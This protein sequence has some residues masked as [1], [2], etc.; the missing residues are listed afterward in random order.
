VTMTYRIAPAPKFASL[1]EWDCSRCGRREVKPVFLNDGTGAKAFGSGCAARLL[2][3][4]EAARKIRDEFDAVQRAADQA[5]EMRVERVA[6]YGR[7]IAAFEADPNAENPD[8][9]SARQAYHSLGGFPQLGTFPV[10]MAQV[11]ETGELS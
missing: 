1:Y 6:R 2:G 11:A 7:A 9:T 4:P 3:R 8:L 10:W 5:E